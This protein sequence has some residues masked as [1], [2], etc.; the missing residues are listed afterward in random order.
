MAEYIISC[1][2]MEKYNWKIIHV[3]FVLAGNKITSRIGKHS[4]SN[5][6]LNENSNIEA[7]YSE[8]SV[9]PCENE[10][11]CM[12]HSEYELSTYYTSPYYALPSEAGG[13]V[14]L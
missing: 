14:S 11:T 7:V 3:L 5:H 9:I 2:N 13:N 6:L 10:L 1:T 12:H 8:A 4:L